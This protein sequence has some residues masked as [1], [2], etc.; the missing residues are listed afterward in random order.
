MR[1]YFDHS[2][3]TPVDKRVVDAM[4]PYYLEIFGNASSLH[5]FGMEAHEAL[6]NSRKTIADKMNANYDELIFTSGGTESDNFALKGIARIFKEKHQKDHV[7]TTKIEHPAI[8]RSVETLE[9]EGFK[10]TLLN[11]DKEGFIDLNQL[12]KEINDNT[13]LVSIMHANNEIGTIQDLEAIGKICRDKNII[14]HSDAVQAFTK[15]PLDV[16]KYNLDLVSITAHKIHGPKGIGALYISKDLQ[17]KRNVK[18]LIDGGSHEFN[19]RAGTENIPG[20]V[21]FAKAVELATEDNIKHM[22]NLRDMIIK[23]ILDEIPYTQLNGPNIESHGNKRLCNNINFAFKYVEGEAI[24]FRL[25]AEGIAV[26]TG[27]ACASKSLDPSHVLQAIGL[28]VEEGLH[29]TIR[30]SLGRENT[31]EEAEYFIDKLKK[32]INDLRKMSPL[33][34]DR[35]IK[36]E[37]EDCE[38]H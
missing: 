30:A 8:L 38:V 28:T 37:E 25:D 7:I 33:K 22:V 2:A 31:I 36:Y 11:V 17:R 24:L 1:V 21:G 29:G 26:S 16:K 5:E 34:P 18:K 27:S 3:T 20:I 19:F 12:E 6:D 13:I 32:V 9:N 4:L 23:T 14:F 10:I 15:V 35:N